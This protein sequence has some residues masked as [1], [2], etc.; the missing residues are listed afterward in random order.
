[1]KKGDIGV[2]KKRDL[3]ALSMKMEKETGIS[4]HIINVNISLKNDI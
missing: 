1:M 3:D 4:M 2:W